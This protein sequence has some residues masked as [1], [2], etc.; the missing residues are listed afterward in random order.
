MIRLIMTA[1]FMV[2][3]L[4][5]SIVFLPICY[6]I[7]FINKKAGKNFIFFFVK[8][9]ARSL[10]V[11]AG[12]KTTVTGRENLK[13]LKSNPVLFVGNHRGI[14]DIPL[15]YGYSPILA[16]FVAKKELTKIPIVNLWMHC[17][18]C[19][20]IDR[21]SP[22][23][24]IKTI[25]K[26]IER[27]KNNG[28]SLFIFPEGTRSKTAEMGKFKGGSLR[29]SEKSGCPIVPVAILGADKIFEAN[30]GKFKSGK[31]VVAFG[32]PVWYDKLSDE[33]KKNY[34]E[35]IKNRVQELIDGHKEGLY[36]NNK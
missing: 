34:T 17:I 32:E 1:L 4:I 9:W 11:F 30:K 35:I 16:G 19:L 12:V 7:R 26:G 27:L 22:K 36:R 6:L 5:C 29:L 25:N 3:F 14:L 20:F 21:S 24:G 33:D 18:G 2:V 8:I 10:L 31:C 13:E 15:F 28:D 23:A